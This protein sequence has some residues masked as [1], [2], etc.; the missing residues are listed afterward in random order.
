MFTGIIEEIA[1]VVALKKEGSNLKISCKSNISTKL[2]IDQSVSHNGVCLTV[3]DINKNIHT[4]TVIKETLNKS[5]L[6]TLKLGSKVN[7]E[8]SLKLNSRLDG[9]MVQGHIDKVAVCTSIKEENGSHLF[10]FKYSGTDNLTVE[11]GSI[12]VN[13]V[14]LTVVDSKN[15]S[16]SIAVIPYTYQNTNLQLIKEGDKVNIEFDILGKYIAKMFNKKL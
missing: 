14:S 8:R 2:K 12:S 13:G 5:N 9:H 3:I 16:F 4:V 7:L 11:K 15:I 1:E 10:T 6:G